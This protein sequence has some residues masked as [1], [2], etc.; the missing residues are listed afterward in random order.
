MSENGLISSPWKR[1]VRLAGLAG[2]VGASMTGQKLLS[3]AM[4]SSRERR[5]TENLVKNASRLVET[6]GELK[7][8]A[9]KVGQMLSLHET[10][11]PPE[12]AAVLRTLQKQAPHIPFALVKARLAEEIPDRDR[13]FASIEEEAFASASIGQ[14]HR[15]TLRDGRK[16]AIKIQYPG[17]DKVVEAD[18]SNLR[19]VLKS[20]VTRIVDINF[21]TVWIELRARLREELDYLNE[22]ANIRRMAELHS[23]IPEIVI[24]R[25]IDEATTR[26][27]LTME[28]VPGIPPDEA[29]SDEYPQGL[30]DCWG[31]V[32]FEFL[33]RGLLVHR[34]LHADPNLANFAFLANGAVIVYDFGC[35]KEV[36]AR[37]TRGYRDLSRAALYAKR[38][39]I[40]SIL[41][42]MG[43][44][45][46][47]GEPLPAEMV[48]PYLDL[49]LELLEPDENYRFGENDRVYQRLFDLG[50]S[51]IGNL[52][53]IQFPRDIIFINRTVGGHFGNLSRLHAAGPWRDSLEGFCEKARGR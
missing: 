25:V 26:T 29:C 7:G 49:V 18:L 44:H 15:A 43:I 31:K 10:V 40:P 28:Y 19:R 11:L 24:P 37:I 30:K 13:I 52:P 1:L 46:K 36:P 4:P 41:A 47:D 48:D 51:N 5:Q 16:V 38:D 39:E 8:A 12:V 20:L 32:L 50:W 21:D 9:M 2:K 23:G 42:K 27:V 6:L 33:L 35:V 53:G 22:A 14:V 17:I 3:L 45:K 34:V